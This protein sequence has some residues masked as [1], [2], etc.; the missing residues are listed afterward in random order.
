MINNFIFTCY[1]FFCVKRSI[2]MI[3][4]NG[5]SVNALALNSSLF[6][7][8][9]SLPRERWGCI[10]TNTTSSSFVLRLSLT[11]GCRGCFLTNTILPNF[12]FCL[13]LS[14]GCKGHLFTNAM[15]SSLMSLFTLTFKELFSCLT[16][17]VSFSSIFFSQHLSISVLRI[18]ITIIIIFL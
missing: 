17:I 4:V 8:Y 1:W 5:I 10:L 6:V 2:N 7:F 14:C 13:S 18:I 3:W 9:L 15:L 12:Y 11:W 16:L